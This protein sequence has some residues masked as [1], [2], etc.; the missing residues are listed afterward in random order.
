MFS[1]NFEELLNSRQLSE[2]TK[3]TYR[4]NY[5]LL[6]S[7]FKS[8]LINISDDVMI[9][10]IDNLP[11]KASSK[12]N[13][14]LIPIMI[15]TFNN[16]NA[17]KLAQHRLTYK[18][19]IAKDAISNNVKQ[20]ETGKTYKDFKNWLKNLET[21]ITEQIDNENM[22][23]VKGATIYIIN[24]LIHDYQVRNEDLNLKIVDGK[25]VLENGKNYLVVGS[26]DVTYIRDKYKTRNIYGKKEHRITNKVFVKLCKLLRGRYLLS[27]SNGS[28]IKD[29][30]LSSFIGDRTYRQLGEGKI[31]K[32]IVQDAF[33]SKNVMGTLEKLANNRGSGLEQLKAHYNLNGGESINE[34]V[35][36]D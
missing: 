11:S 9:S 3:S 33:T 8:D 19:S 23:D 5:N 4:A 6:K 28:Q 17:D 20:V 10:H 25:E 15:K 30:S 2:K 13:V 1:D 29:S 24:F 27:V 22:V 32:L 18:A 26:K 31:F 35:L 16:V 34:Y 36:D 7:H 14:M 21:K 12:Y